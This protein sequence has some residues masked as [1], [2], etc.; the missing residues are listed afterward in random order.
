MAKIEK[1]Y[2]QRVGKNEGCSC[3]KCGQYIT[4]IWTVRYK[5]SADI[6]FGMDCF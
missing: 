1:I 4:N 5:G 3:D 2:F 6:H